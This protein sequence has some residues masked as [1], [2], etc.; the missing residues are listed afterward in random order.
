MM[1][2]RQQFHPAMSVLIE[3][4]AGKR[5]ITRN[6]HFAWCDKCQSDIQ[7]LSELLEST[8][9]EKTSDHQGVRLG[10]TA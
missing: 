2:N 6:E 8:P 5:P 3:I 4:A 9:Q 1:S 10:K 7:W